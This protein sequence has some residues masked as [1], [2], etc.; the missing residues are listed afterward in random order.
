M[1]VC[2]VAGP[3]SADTCQCTACPLK[4]SCLNDRAY[5]DVSDQRVCQ[6]HVTIR[7]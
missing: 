5:H 4:H 2:F 1:S 3:Q 6:R 7:P